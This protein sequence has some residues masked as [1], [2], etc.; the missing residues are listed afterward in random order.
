[1]ERADHGN[2]HAGYLLEQILHLDAVFAADVEIVAAGFAGPVV[3]VRT[4]EGD[5]LHGAETAE[6][7]GGEEQPVLF[8]IGDHDLGPVDHGGHH[9][10]EGMAAERERVAFLNGQRTA[11]Q[12]DAFEEL[13]KH[14]ERGGRGY[15]R[16]GRIGFQHPGDKGGMVGLHMVDHQVIRLAVSERFGQVGLPGFA[17]AGVGRI[18]HGD[19]PVED[20]IGIVGH[21][22]GNVVL[23]LEQ[24]EVEVVD[25]DKFD[26]GGDILGHDRNF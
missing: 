2:L 15:E 16:D 6:G 5:F 14:L 22:F 10:T 20:H 7:I 25:A 1:M 23:A 11:F 12:R 19:F 4:P 21:S 9:E 8:V 3:V 26:G 24:V 18:E 13:R 17:L